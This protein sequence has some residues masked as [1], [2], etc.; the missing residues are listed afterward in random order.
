[1]ASGSFLA[2]SRECTHKPTERLHGSHRSRRVVGVSL[3]KEPNGS[4]QDEPPGGAGA[5]SCSGVKSS[6]PKH[7]RGIP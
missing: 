3:A 4:D 7:L 5:V 6:V 1:M 2:L